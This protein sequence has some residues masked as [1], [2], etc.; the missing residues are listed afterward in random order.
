MN[1]GREGKVRGPGKHPEKTKCTI[2]L[3][4]NR[5]RR[6][7]GRGERAGCPRLLVGV[8]R[9]M[10]LTCEEDSLQQAEVVLPI[11]LCDP[12]AMQGHGQVHLHRDCLRERHE[13]TV[14]WI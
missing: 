7:P 13:S 8:R 1:R 14:V 3:H 4:P 9:E 6:D 11:L 12:N 2:H 10:L 5:L